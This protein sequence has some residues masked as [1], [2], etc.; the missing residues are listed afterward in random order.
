MSVIFVSRC[1]SRL[2]WFSI[3]NNFSNVVFDDKSISVCCL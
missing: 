1:A 3:E 2:N